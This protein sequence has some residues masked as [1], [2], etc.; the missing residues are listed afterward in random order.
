MEK[1]K[2]GGH[3]EFFPKT[4]LN[5]PILVRVGVAFDLAVCN[6]SAIDF[7]PIFNKFNP[8]IYQIL[9]FFKKHL[10]SWFPG[11]KNKQED[12]VQLENVRFYKKN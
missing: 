8:V 10:E 7:F 2:L 5:L 1:V 3:F 4:F 12:K 9:D 11:S 6:S